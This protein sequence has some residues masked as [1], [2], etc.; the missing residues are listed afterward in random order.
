MR[1]ESELSGNA[2]STRSCHLWVAGNFGA[3]D[4]DAGGH[5][6][7]FGETGQGLSGEIYH[8]NEDFQPA[9]VGVANFRAAV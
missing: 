1:C 9:L 8:A 2:G 3:V 4:L 7:P 5:L 6:L